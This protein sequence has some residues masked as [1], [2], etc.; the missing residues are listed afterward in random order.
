[1][2]TDPPYASGGMS[3]DSRAQPTS[4]KYTSHKKDCPFPDFE[5][6]AKDQRSW[7]RW[8]TEW[9][10]DARRVCKPGAPI[11]L[12]IDWRQLPALTDA[13]QWAGWIW[14]GVAVWDKLNSRPQK[15]RFRQQAEFIVWGS[16]GP[17]P[18]TREAP[19]LP[20]VFRYAMP[21][22]RIHQTEKPLELMKD[23]I[24]ICEPG[25]HILDP[26]AGSG[27]T[28]EA[29]KIE[30]YD[31]TGIELVREYVDAGNKRIKTL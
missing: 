25:G 15:G 16:N 12:F 11:C 18:S 13:M 19:F 23:I 6:D 22:R 10:I 29:A 2:I 3:K 24:H 31:A 7:T 14:R 20:G 9:M 27:T 4:K 30:G 8:M 26:F 21:Q 1:V 5:G 17:M 28:L